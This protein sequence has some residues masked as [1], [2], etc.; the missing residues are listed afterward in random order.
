MRSRDPKDPLDG[1]RPGGRRSYW[2][3]EAL[4][5]EPPELSADVAAPPLTGTTRADIAI[6]G[7]G[8]TGLWTAL[9]LTELAPA[10][11]IVV[12][13]SDICGGGASGRNGGFVTGWWDELPG[14]ISRFGVDAV[15]TARALDA[16]VEEIGTWTAANGVDAWYTPAGF[17][18]VSAA[19]AQ[20]GAW[21]EATDA[22]A[23]LGFAE[24]WQALS[25]GRGRGPRPLA[26]VPRRRV[27]AGSRDDPTGRAR[28]GPPA[29]CTRAW[30]RHP[31]ADARRALRRRGWRIRR[32]LHDLGRT[33]P[34]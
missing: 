8:Y 24:R 29:G 32:R 4:A 27:H 31:R 10:A 33:D 26:G 6:L 2:L 14:L 17:L 3:R 28:Q 7:G 13:E 12:V 11:R 34:A 1:V 9:R 25:R 22:C 30:R 18:S 23:R 21:T 5:A 15:R 16:A 19:P 20:D